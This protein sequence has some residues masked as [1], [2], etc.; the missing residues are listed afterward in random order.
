[1]QKKIIALAVAGVMAAPMAAMAGV[2]VYG[3][4]RMSI[5]QVSNDQPTDDSSKMSISSH[6]SRLGF[7]GNEDLGGGLKAVW[8]AEGTLDMDNGGSYAMDR[9]TFVGLAGNFGTVFLGQ[10]DTPY[11]LATAKLDIF[12]D[13]FADY[14]SVI[15]GTH[16]MRADNVLAYV[17]PDMN[18]FQVVAA[19]VTSV[20]NLGESDNLADGTAA[21]NDAFSISASYNNGPLFVSLAYQNAA[22]LGVTTSD[23]ATATKL[24]LGYTF[25]G[26]TDVGLVYESIDNGGTGATD[27]AQDNIYLSV[28]HRIG[29]NTLKLALGQ[30]GDM[31]DNNDT[32]ADFLALGVSRNL[33]KST[34]VYALY[35][36]LA[37][38]KS[39]SYDLNG[40]GQT[41]GSVGNDETVDAFAVGINHKFSS[42]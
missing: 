14:N 30:K 24:G 11:K 3:Q 33:S 13:T 28:A 4:A 18:G 10:H 22:E 9:N 31:G 5:G 32:G 38:A 6:N 8:Q 39:A 23:D 26:A 15:D 37:N 16:D 42:M 2:E 27:T 1:M 7:R 21:S 25:A 20:E 17:S 41:V 12:T 35:T 40:G 19:Y 36:S 29:D 34:E